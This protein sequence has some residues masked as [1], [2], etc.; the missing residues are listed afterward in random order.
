MKI[1]LAGSCGSTRRTIMMN[2]ATK[3]R[4]MGFDVHCPFELKIADAWEMSQEDWAGE[5]FNAD[6]KAI[7]ECDVMVCISVGRLSTA[8]TNWEQGYAYGIGKPCHVFQVTEEQ[9]SLMTFW[10]CTSFTNTNLNDLPKALRAVL[11]D[12]HR[13]NSCKTILT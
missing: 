5:V 12:G 6:I 2:I 8:G 9:T 13:Q 11:I 4:N 1:Y 10:G 3:L 7:E